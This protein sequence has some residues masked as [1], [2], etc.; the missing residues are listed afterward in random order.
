M[1][2]EHGRLQSK[3]QVAGDL[4]ERVPDILLIFEKLCVSSVL[5]A[6]VLFG[7]KHLWRTKRRNA[8]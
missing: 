4:L 6:E 2:A 3:L 5:E 1:S 7:R 8:A